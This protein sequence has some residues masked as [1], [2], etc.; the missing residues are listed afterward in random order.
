MLILRGWNN[1][2]FFQYAALPLRWRKN[3]CYSSLLFICIQFTFFASIMRRA[4]TV[5]IWVFL[6][7]TK[8]VHLFVGLLDVFSM[9]AIKLHL[10]IIVWL[11]MYTVWIRNK[12]THKFVLEQ[13]HRVTRHLASTMLMDAATKTQRRVDGAGTSESVLY[14]GL[15]LES[16]DI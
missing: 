11:S 7:F 13:Y 4:E 15:E 6:L 16:R 5:L 9:F 1:D 14:S 12:E 8:F 3:K 2:S 10:K